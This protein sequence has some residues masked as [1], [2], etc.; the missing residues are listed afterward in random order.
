MLKN[1]YDEPC[2]ERV[3]VALDCPQAQALNLARQ[4]AGYARWVK[5]GMTLYYE[6]G[7]AIV[8]ELKALGFKVFLDLKMHDIPHQVEGGAL[9][10]AQTG[11]DMLTFHCL[12]GKTM[13]EAARRGLEKAHELDA[14]IS[15]ASL[16]ITI[17]TSHSQSDLEQIGLEGTISQR[18]IALAH[19][20]RTSGLTGVV[21]SPF[22]AQ[23]LRAELG[24]DAFIVTPGI[25]LHAAENDDQKRIATPHM[26]F[27]AGASHIVVGRPITQAENPVDA[28]KNICVDI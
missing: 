14:N 11:A 7:P 4:L 3:I 26:A 17:L 23:Q 18:V 19:L 5:V 25:R 21:A 20:A 12:G 15:C 1:F 24:K 22:E 16:G 6:A 27:E 9:S 10:A 28:F 13:L 2:S 8:K